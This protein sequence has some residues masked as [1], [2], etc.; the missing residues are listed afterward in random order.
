MRSLQNEIDARSKRNKSRIRTVVLF[1]SALIPLAGNTASAD[2]PTA[3]LGEIA[4][5]D[6]AYDDGTKTRFIPLELVVPGKW[7]GARKIESPDKVDFV[8]GGGDRWSGPI[9]D[10]D[11]TTGRPIIAFMRVRTTRREGTVTQRF[12]VREEDDGI[13]RVYDSRFGEIRCS[14]EIKFPL[15]LWRE[16]ETRRNEYVCAAKSGKPNRR[17]NIITIEKVDFPCRGVPH[18]LQFT[19]RHHMEGKTE[20]LDDRRYIFAPGLGQIAAERR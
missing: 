5:W 9:A 17:S 7:S 10:A 18:C 15:G 6:S 8:D 16:G 14:G 19:W 1:L 12:A 11:L 20:P 3:R 4:V 13:G 2:W